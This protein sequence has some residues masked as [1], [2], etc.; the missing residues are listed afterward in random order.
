MPAAFGKFFFRHGA[1]QRG[2]ADFVVHDDAR[3][4]AADGVH[5]RQIC[6]GAMQRGN[7]VMIMIIG[8]RLRLR[9]PRHFVG[10]HCLAINH[11]GKFIIARTEIKTDAA[12]LQMPAGRKLHLLR[13]RNFF[14]RRDDD[15]KFFPVVRRHHVTVKFAQ[16]AWRILLADVCADLFRPAKVKFP[17]AARPQQKFH[18]PLGVKQRRHIR[19]RQH[20]RLVTRDE[21][22]LSLQPDHKR[23]RPA[24]FFRSGKVSAVEQNRRLELRIKRRG[25]NSRREIHANQAW[26]ADDNSRPARPD[27]FHSTPSAF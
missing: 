6:G 19:F 21:F 22:M 23:H 26:T 8:I 3:R 9:V 18:Q 1:Q 17:A 25:K 7:N 5:A 27:V 12:A 15:L 4:T 13:R 24:G 20:H 11:G 14:R 2:H 10:E 16:A